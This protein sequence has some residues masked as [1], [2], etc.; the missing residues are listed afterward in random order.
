MVN[1]EAQ[2]ERER[3]YNKLAKRY[4][5]HFGENYGVSP[6]DPRS[7]EEHM[8]EM[9]KCIETN[10]KAVDRYFEGVVGG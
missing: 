2:L 3:P 4:E 8:E 7:R 5:E 1:R 9:R 6:A 10:T